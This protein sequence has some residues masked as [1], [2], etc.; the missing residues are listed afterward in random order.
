[1]R[2]NHHVS[3]IDAKIRTITLRGRRQRACTDPE[4]EKKDTTHCWPVVAKVPK[5]YHTQGPVPRS[6]FFS[7]EVSGDWS[8]L[9]TGSLMENLCFP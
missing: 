7:Y 1:M 8:S 3:L 4:V 5:L 9:S 2:I 6:C